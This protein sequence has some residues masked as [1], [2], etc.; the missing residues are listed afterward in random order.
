MHDLEVGV[1][2]RG[3]RST[4]L[5]RTR[6]FVAALLGASALTAVA[7]PAAE[8]ATVASGFQ[9]TVVLNGLSNPMAV[10]FA[11]DGRVFVAEKSGRIKVFPGLGTGQTPTTF[12]DLSTK[13]HDFWDRG[14]LGMT[15]DP[16]FPTNPYVYVLYAHDAVPGGTAP[17]WGDGCPSNPGA[18]TDGCLISGRLSR[19]TASGNTM[20]GTEQVLINDWCQQ[21]PS[22]SVGTLLFGRDGALYASSGDGASFNGVDYGQLGGTL[23]PVVTAA[24]PCGDPPL[25]AGTKLAPP[26]A[27][28]G[29][30]RSQSMRRP[31]G[32]ATLDGAIL[33]VDPAT[34][35]GLPG[36]PFASSSD[37]N[38]RRIVAYG[39]RNP[40][41]MTQR[42][43]TDEL[44]IG[45]VGWNEWE[46]INRLT[47]PTGTTGRNFGWPCYEGAG[48]QPGYQGAGLNSCS[49]LAS[50]DVVA[51][52]Y[53][54]RHA[55][56]VVAYTGCATGGA[57]IT[58]VAFH[59]GSGYGPEY[60]G[61]LFFGD[62][63][64]N[65]IWAMLPDTAGGV[66]NP[67]KLRT[68]VGRNSTGGAGNPVELLA[69]PNGDIFYVDMEGG[70]VHR[71][72]YTAANQPPTARASATPTTGSAP[73]AVAFDGSASTDPE[74]RALTYDWDFDGN[75]TTDSTA[76]KPTHTYTASGSFTARLRVTDDG[77]ASSTATVTITVGNTPPAPVINSP[78]SSTLWKVGDTFTF[79]GRATDTQDG[80]LP[81]SALSWTATL[82][83]C[84]TPT[85][86][87]PHAIQ[88]WNGVTSGS[89]TA[90][91]HAEPAYLDLTLTATDSGGL[92]SSTTV[93]LNPQTVN[94]TFATKPGGLKLTN[95]VVGSTAQTT[96][97]TVTV[98][99]NSLN[100]VSA[101]SPQTVNKS[102]Y[103][104]RSWSDG[105]AQ[106]HDIKAPATATTYTATYRK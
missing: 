54:Y 86:C 13:V 28:G 106:A 71:L 15:L 20:T 78:S 27:E 46:E 22:H 7:L 23:S 43:N 35:A 11:S 60:D 32:P 37:A 82:Q 19:L 6:G 24:N 26:S 70:S 66:P 104:W 79:S 102:T 14:L 4:S 101:P 41:R 53:A 52:H 2:I 99:V 94:L 92:K 97:F 48:T 77:G 45:D 1:A 100:S 17:R 74:G 16:N 69:G 50:T 65:E 83:H 67:T 90:P 58:G 18:T 98:V 87:H 10:R 64:R 29:A 81:A 91:D 63:S 80:T 73:L 51:P 9:D 57:S 75:G 61:A 38:A 72:T 88:S 95:L 49:T 21:Y 55:N 30:L 59:T 89:F 76:V 62:H 103:L 3:A 85:S 39:F 5:R 68:I 25:P 93:R 47:V 44:W 105:G 56:C 42:P 33:R 12:A 96:P 40:F 84:A 34:G 36:N 31:S 8:A